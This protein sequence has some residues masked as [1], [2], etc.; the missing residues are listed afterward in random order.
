[1]ISLTS[2]AGFVSTS[3]P[4]RLTTTDISMQTTHWS[5]S[6]Q[7]SS[8]SVVSIIVLLL[9]LYKRPSV[10]TLSITLIWLTWRMPCR[11]QY[12][13]DH[14]SIFYLLPTS[15]YFP[16]AVREIWCPYFW[17]QISSPDA[18]WAASSY[19]ALCCQPQC[20]CISLLKCT[21]WL[22]YQIVSCSLLNTQYVVH[23]LHAK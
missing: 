1:M 4:R 10:I 13:M 3:A 14:S 2:R 9:N 18:P 19:V 7:F 20:C 16:L 22:T 11:S 6:A 12:N 21:I 5:I 17:L 23:I 8:V 15:S